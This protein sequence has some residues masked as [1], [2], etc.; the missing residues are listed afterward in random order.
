MW[1]DVEHNLNMFQA[2]TQFSAYFW[3]LSFLSAIAE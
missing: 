2:N 1:D 3:L